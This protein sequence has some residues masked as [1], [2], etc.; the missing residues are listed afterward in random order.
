MNIKLNE[1]IRKDPNQEFQRSLS[2]MKTAVLGGNLN[3][4]Q[5]LRGSMSAAAAGMDFQTGNR[6]KNLISTP[7]SQDVKYGSSQELIGRVGTGI[8]LKRKI[9]D[10]VRRKL[11]KNLF[12]SNKSLGPIVEPITYETD[13]IDPNL[14]TRKPETYWD[15][16]DPDLNLTFGGRPDAFDNLMNWLLELIWGSV[17][18]DSMTPQQLEYAM[19]NM[20]NWAQQMDD[21]ITN[22]PIGGIGW[23]QTPNDGWFA[24]SHDGENGWTIV[25]YHDSWPGFLGHPFDVSTHGNVLMNPLWLY[26]YTV[27]GLRR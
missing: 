19:N 25:S 12:E 10:S 1:S 6:D 23:I 24:V 20:G 13:E 18:I 14:L 5:R 7:S 16:S 9:M 17:T 26:I 27:N 21:F 4:A 3:Q 15:T 22:I 2:R 8:A 11:N